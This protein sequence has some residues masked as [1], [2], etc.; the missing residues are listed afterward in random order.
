MI[1]VGIS[2]MLKTVHGMISDDRFWL[3]EFATG[4]KGDLK[5]HSYSH[6][7]AEGE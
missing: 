2:E 5:F 6:D 3:E 1:N 7:V 4:G